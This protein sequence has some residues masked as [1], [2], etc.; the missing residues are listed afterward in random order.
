MV[1]SGCK[2]N[3]FPIPCTSPNFIFTSHFFPPAPPKKSSL[4]CSASI[5]NYLNLL[6]TFSIETSLDLG[7]CRTESNS[8]PT[9]PLSS[10]YQTQLFLHVVAFGLVCSTA[11]SKWVLLFQLTQSAWYFDFLSRLMSKQIL[12]WNMWK[13]PWL[14]RRKR[15]KLFWK[16]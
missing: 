7:K 6:K 12:I 14:L 13:N 16:A 9:N 15:R 3:Q 4:M 11:C 1:T 10:D 5:C 2:G 8:P